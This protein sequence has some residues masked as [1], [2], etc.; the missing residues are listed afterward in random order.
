MRLCIPWLASQLPRRKRSGVRGST[1]PAASN[2]SILAAAVVDL[3]AVVGLLGVFGHSQLHQAAFVPQP[4]QSKT[5]GRFDSLFSPFSPPQWRL[6][7]LCVQ[8]CPPNEEDILFILPMCLGGALNPGLC[9]GGRR[10]GHRHV[11]HL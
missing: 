8:Y 4:W 11:F 7:S 6:D 2:Y 9:Q 10:N 1:F 3:S 5:V